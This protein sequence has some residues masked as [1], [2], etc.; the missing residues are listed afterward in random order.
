MDHAQLCLGLAMCMWET[1]YYVRGMKI[2][3]CKKGC[4]G[5]ASDVQQRSV[6]VDAAVVN[7]LDYHG[8]GQPHSVVHT[9]GVLYEE[10]AAPP[11]ERLDGLKVKIWFPP[12]AD[13]AAWKQL[14]SDLSQ[15]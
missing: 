4:M 10:A 5:A 1:L 11:F 2:H 14:D 13:K 9:Q 12:V 6:V 3:R 15:A 7:S 8:R